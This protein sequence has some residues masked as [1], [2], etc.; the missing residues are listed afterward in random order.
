MSWGFEER[1]VYNRRLD[2]HGKYGGQQQGG[3][4]TPSQ[5]P[6]VVII[7]GEEGLEHGYADRTR[8]DGA[9]EYFGEGQ[10]GDMTM[11]RGNLAIATHA[12]EGK[13]LLLFRKTSE[14]L[15]FLSE[16]AYEKHHIER[17]PD[18]EN[19]ERD[20]IVFELRS[21]NAVVEATEDA[22]PEPTQTLEQLRALAKA[23]AGIFPP[24]Q[25]A[26]VRNIYQ[27]SRDV[28][29]YVLM[30]AAGECE[31]CK[32][33]APFVRKNGSPYLEPHHIRRASDGGPDD[34]A[35]VIALCPNCHRRVHA[36]NDGN[37][38]N[39]TLLELMSNIEPN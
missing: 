36:G 7:T 19:N 27:R 15:R 23:S 1:R 4:I 5:H 2:I 29:T 17:A 31:G 37:L 34:P 20:A 28:K 35:F 12:A 8:D 11:Q 25:V 21:L 14:G 39:D 16:M 24:T 18:R 9:F 10:L 3:I 30:R 22:A 26:G 32:L 6:L 33:P 38:Y 13:S